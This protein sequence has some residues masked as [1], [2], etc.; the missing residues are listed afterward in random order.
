[1]PVLEPV[2]ATILADIQQYMASME[3]VKA[4]MDDVGAHSAVTSAAVKDSG[5]ALAAASNDAALA[6]NAWYDTGKAS[7]DL[8]S[9]VDDTNGKTNILGSLLSKLPG[10]LGDV[11]GKTE[12]FA[13][14]MEKAGTSGGG[15]LSVLTQ[16]PNAYVLAGAAVAAVGAIAVKFGLDYQ[17]TTDRIAANGQVTIQTAQS[18]ASAFTS[19]MGQTTMSASEIAQAFAPVA[20]QVKMLNGGTLNAAAAMDVMRASIDAAEATGNSL[21]STTSSLTQML[22]TFGQKASS[23][24]E[25]AGILTVSANDTGQSIGKVTNAIDRA[26]SRLG[27]MSPPLG[28]LSAL[29]VD[30]TAHGETGRQAMTA[31]GTTFTTFLKPATAV[32]TAQKN[33]KMATDNLPPSLDALAKQYETGTMHA[34]QVTAA[35]KG[36]DTAQTLLWGKFKSA[37]DASM[38]AGEAY[39]KLGFNAVGANGKLLPMADIIGKL[40]DQI[41]GMTNAQAQATLSAD[42]FG[43]SAAKILATIQAGPAVFQKY[44]DAVTKKDAAETAAAKATSSLK[45]QMEKLVS[46]VEDLFLNLG[47]KLIPIITAVAKVFTDLLL[48]VLQVALSAFEGVIVVIGDVIKWFKQMSAPAIAV[49]AVIGTLLIPTIISFA[50]TVASSMMDAVA[51]AAW[52]FGA[53]ID[54]VVGWTIAQGKAIVESVASIG[55]FIIEHTIAAATYIAQNVAMAASAT[56]AFIAENAATLGI[57]AVIALL[58][59]GIVWV[60]THWK[61]SWNAIKE[62]AEAVWHAIEAVW[63]GIEAAFDA[64]ISWIESHMKML[65]TI[66][67]AVMT[68]GLGLL[69]MVIIDHWNQIINGVSSMISAVV[70]FFERLPF[71]ILN[72]LGD[73]GSLLFDAGK[74]LLEGLIHGIENG[75]D[76]V[77]NTVKNIGHTVMNAFKSVLSIF[78]PSKV[79]AGYGQNIMEG[80]AQ[81]ISDNA[82][83]AHNAISGVGA[84]LSTNFSLGVGN[85]AVGAISSP[86]NA[87]G[88]TVLNVTSPIQVNGQTIAQVVTQYQ[89]QNARATGTVLGQYSGGSQTGAATGI[90]VN[91]ISR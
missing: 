45:G 60:A 4:E 7:R 72:A 73:F 20:G 11:Q 37:A 66:I 19:T 40:R 85:G 25:D 5:G 82:S 65:A 64:A 52:G 59:A 33:L 6:E 1:M 70:G 63:H 23:S 32:V 67:V 43:S 42:G 68:G 89:L 76:G 18:I 17:N 57:V 83:L 77:V 55:S 22:Q 87:G 24:A 14:S 15:F 13:G 78:S 86:V 10:P 3:A 36:L 41:K 26:R 79:F 27:S 38:T 2:V 47:M 91:A 61:E 75:V 69:V 16:I 62:A 84:D 29:L 48:P 8:S 81:G 28:E 49:A 54:S 12:Q 46:G 88:P 56:A 35:T 80:L 39:Q 74:N 21:K 30:L 50:T 58:V 51:S 90:N 34:S 53:M 44:Q 71:Y 31:L 9:A